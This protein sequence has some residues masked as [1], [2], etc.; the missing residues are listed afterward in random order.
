MILALD[1]ETNAALAVV[2]SLG[3][4]GLNV[5]V[6]GRTNLS[7]S[8][9]SKYCTKSTIYTSPE[10]N[11]KKFTTQLL[12]M[13]KNG[14]YEMIVPTTDFSIMPIAMN[15]EKIEKNTLVPLPSNEI[16]NIA[17]KKS[18]TVMMAERLKIPV[19]KTFFPTSI[20]DLKEVESE[21]EYPVVVKPDSSKIAVGNRIMDAQVRFANNMEELVTNFRKLSLG[22]IK[23]IIQEFIKGYGLGFFSLFN[24]SKPRAI[25]MH[26]RLREIS[27]DRGASTLRESI[28]DKEIEK[29]GLRILKKLKWHG[30]AMVEFRFD[31]RNKKPKLMEINGRF[32]GSL[33]LATASG[34]DFPVLLYRMMTEGDV[35]PVFDYKTG[36]KCRW[37]SGDMYRLATVM[38]GS[39]NR[40]VIS[41]SR[42]K[43]LIEFMKFFGKD[44]HYD[45]FTRDDPL[46][47]FI[48]MANSV[49]KLVKKGL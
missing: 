25:F 9:F 46:P 39:Y 23:P 29:Y 32:W 35:K 1:G 18:E 42:I 7:Q 11:I 12:E 6:A 8:F 43:S 4:Y 16:L 21:I 49:K 15:R 26:K 45:S 10:E 33:A 40:D 20:K 24:N 3:R 34:V 47:G 19:P 30:V 2:R 13:T 44:L 38:T 37:L 5:E 14:K 41:E 36:V 17:W 48:D 31:E 22:G 28:Q 27:V